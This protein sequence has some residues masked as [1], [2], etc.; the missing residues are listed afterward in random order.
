MGGNSM[1]NENA[2]Q[3]EDKLVGPATEA[4]KEKVV[5]ITK[6]KF[7]N[8][9]KHPNKNADIVCI[10]KQGDCVMVTGLSSSGWARVYTEAGLMGYVVADYIKAV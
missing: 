6:C 2:Q 1:E 7:L 5:E 3:L 8:M 10:L 9:R 4:G